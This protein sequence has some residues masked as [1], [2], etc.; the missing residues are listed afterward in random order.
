MTKLMDDP[1]DAGA[2]LELDKINKRIK[3]QNL[4]NKLSK[5]DLNNF[6]VQVPTFIAN[7][8]M[9]Q[10]SYKALRQDPNDN[11]AMKKV[12]SINDV[13][14]QLNQRHGYPEIWQIT[15]PD[16]SSPAGAV[17][18][19]DASQAGQAPTRGGVKTKVGVPIPDESNGRTSLGKVVNVRKAGFGSRVIVNR[20]TEQNPYFEIYPGAEFGKGV[21]RDWLEDGTYRCEDLPKNTEAK[22]MEIYE[23]A[24]VKKTSR[25][26]ENKTTRTQSEIQYYLI[27]VGAQN[28][29]SIR[30][31]LSGM[32][33]LSAV[34]LKRID[35]QLDHQNEQLLT[36]LDNCREHNEHPD[37]DEQLT[38]ADIEEM[39]W[40]SPDTIRQTEDDQGKQDDDD[41]QDIENIV[42]QRAGLKRNAEPKAATHTSEL[43]ESFSNPTDTEH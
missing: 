7:F 41:D 5:E 13:L 20:G 42:P 35:V 14:T 38:K 31:A 24:K 28:Y 21:A 1:K 34:K 37:T 9:A 10:D 25:K 23:R 40:L 26:V 18:S 15:I 3:E 39:P 32:K 22:N 8:E 4:R 12:R 36:E 6:L 2:K 11:V 33:G 43:S 17:V 16:G 29:V 30:S 19:G 27:K